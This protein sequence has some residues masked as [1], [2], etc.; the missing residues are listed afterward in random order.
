MNISRIPEFS[1]QSFDGM[2]L[3]FA[4]MSQSRLLFHPDDPASEIYD[5]ATGNK[6]FSSAESRQLDKIIGTMFELHGHQVYEAAYPE[7]MKCM[8][9]NPEV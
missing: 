8:A 6:T 5:I 2:K 3:W 9:I 4:T 1:N 7:F